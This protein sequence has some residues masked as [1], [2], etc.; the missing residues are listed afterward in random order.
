VRCEKDEDVYDVMF[1]FSPWLFV[2]TVDTSVLVMLVSSGR[3]CCL[4]SFVAVL[5]KKKKFSGYEEL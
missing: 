4:F 1:F 5:L 2:V 3:F